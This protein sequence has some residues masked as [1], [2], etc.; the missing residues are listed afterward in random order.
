VSAATI[1]NLVNTVKDENIPYIFYAELSTRNVAKLV[2]EQTGVGMLLLHSVQNVTCEE[3]DS[4]ETYFSLM[5]QNL[6]N[7]ER[8][9]SG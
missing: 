7:L 1:A 4:G 5:Q 6:V 3:F 9:L 8:G 2:S